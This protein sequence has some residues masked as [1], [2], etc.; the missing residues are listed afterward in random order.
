L[1]AFLT[2]V[3]P[4]YNCGRYL[5]AAVASV[6]AQSGI[7]LN[8]TQIIVVDDESTDDTRSVVEAMPGVVYLRQPHAG[9]AAA[10][11]AGV[12]A[13][14][15]RWLAFLDADD[16]WAADKIALQMRCLS[17]QGVDMVFGQAME[18]YSEE[19]AGAS[20][21]K[22]P[23]EVVPARCAG[24]MLLARDTFLRAGDFATAWRVGEFI[25]W[26][27][28]ATDLGLTAA[29]VPQVVLHRRLHA[30]N[31]GRRAGAGR[32]DYIRIIKGAMDRRRAAGS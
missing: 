7:H 21:L 32:E 23:T 9:A 17:T 15:G 5:P 20:E 3:I 12:R 22:A 25:D 4:S 18:F 11:N 6:R 29:M 8:S 14:T 13:A 1:S 19:T 10:R 31:A 27:L 30:D 26:Y 28:R 2:V 16:L 24:T